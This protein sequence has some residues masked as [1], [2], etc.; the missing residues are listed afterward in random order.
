MLSIG[1]ASEGTDEVQAWAFDSSPRSPILGLFLP[2]PPNLPLLR[3]L[4][5]PLNGTW[6]FLQRS[7]GAGIDLGWFCTVLLGVSLS[8]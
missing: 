8:S 3:A 6:G 4:W 2:R 1:V 5:S 7:W